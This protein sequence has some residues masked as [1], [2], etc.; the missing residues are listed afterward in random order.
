MAD[1]LFTP[2]NIDI[3]LPEQPTGG[4]GSLFGLA[5][6][7][8][9]DLEQAVERNQRN[10]ENALIRKVGLNPDSVLG[11]YGNLV[12]SAASGASRLAGNL[13]TLPLD[14]VAGMAQ[15]SVPE[16]RVQAYNRTLRGEATPEDAALLN[17]T[18][19]GDDGV[20]Q[21]YF[22]RLQ[23]TQGIQQASQK[24][25]DFFDIS[26][27]VDTTRRD[28]LS[29][30]IRESTASGVEQLRAAYDAYQN[31]DKYNA[32]V[33]GTQGAFRTIASALGT[34]VTDPGAVAEYV[35]EN[36][37][38]LALHAVAPAAGLATNLGYGADIQREGMTQ[39][40]A[41][42]EGQLPD[43]ED[44]RNMALW[45][46]AAA[47]A[48]QIGDVGLLK[49]IRAAGTGVGRAASGVATSTAREGVTEGFQT[50]AENEAQLKD[51][52]L[53]E[54]VEAA[55]IGALVGGTFQG[56]AE[57][58]NAV[59]QGQAPT[60]E[61][62]PTAEAVAELESSALDTGDV[63]A[64]AAVDPGRAISVLNDL[65]IDAAPEVVQAN[66]R[67]ADD[68]E[69]GLVTQIDDL[70]ANMENNSP[71]AVQEF[72]EILAE[73]PEDAPDAA[74]IRDAI[75]AS[76]SYT[77]A[78]RKQDEATVARLEKQLGEVRQVAERLRVDSTP[79]TDTVVAAAREGNADEALTLTMQNPDAIEPSVAAELSRN[80][81][82]PM[83]QR[84]A[85]STFAAAQEASNALKDRGAVN[86]DVFNGGPGFKGLNQ[87]R[88]A[89]R[90]A[91]NNGNTEKAQAEIQQLA[92]FA[93]T[94]ESKAA[95]ISAAYDSVKGSNKRVFIAPDSTGNWVQTP[96]KQDNG[97]VIN[98][99]SFRL[100]DDVAAEAKALRT[101]AS[102]FQAYAAAPRTTV[103]AEEVATA[104]VG[105]A[106]AAPETAPTQQVEAQEAN[107]AVAETGELTALRNRTGA[108]V[109]SD[110]Y[111]QVNLLGEMFSQETGRD[112][113]A[114]IRPLAAVQDFMSKVRSGEVN[115][116]DFLSQEAELSPNQRTAVNRFFGFQRMLDPFIKQGFTRRR[117]P[118]FRFQDYSQFLINDDGSVDENARTAIAMGSFTWIAENA[119]SIFNTDEGIN[120]ILNRDSEEEVS[121]EAYAVLGKVGTREDVV[122]NQL[123]GRIAQALG[124]RA[125]PEAAA[126]EQA[127]LESALGI[128]A[129]GAMVRAGLL[130]RTEISD[131]TIQRLR[132]TG[133]Q[134]SKAVHTFLNLTTK[135]VDGRV[136]ANDIAQQV[137]E[138]TTGSQSV[139]NKL[140][141][142][143][144]NGTEPSYTPVEF[145]QKFAKR[146]QQ[147]IPKVL[148]DT[149]NKEGAKAHRVRQDMFQ[150]WGNL[151]AQALYRIAGVVNDKPLHIENI[152]S[153]EAK[154]EG[155]MTQV[156]NFTA[157][158]DKMVADPTTDGLEQA[159]HFGRSVWK[160]QR[161]GL[162]TNVIN[163]QTS[164]VHRHMLAM[165]NWETEVDGNDP[166]QLN[167]FKLRVMEAFDKKTESKATALVLQDYDALVS[168]PEVKAAV[169]AIAAMLRGEQ[170][171]SVNYDDVITAAVDQAG[172]NFHSLDALVALA[173][174][175]NSTDGKFKTTFMG[176]VDG[177][178]NGP[179]LS[180]LMLGAKDYSVMNQG[181]FFSVA[182]QYT[183]FNDFKGAGNLDLY[184]STVK[185]ALARLRPEDSVGLAA[186]Q[187]ITG[188]LLTDEGNVT[189]KG[190]NVIKKPFTAMMFGSNT[191]TAVQ[192]MGQGFIDS[193]Y[194]QMERVAEKGDEAGMTQ[195]LEAV[196]TL[197]EKGPKL[198]AKMGIA[199][200]METKLTSAQ[201]NAIAS[202]FFGLLGQHVQSSLEDNYGVFLERRNT[203]NQSAQLAFRLYDAAFNAAVTQAE[204]T[205]PT[206]AR[207]KTRTGE[208]QVLRTLTST[209][210][211][212]IRKKLKPL[213]PILMTAMAKKSGNQ[214]DA[215]M[216][217][218]KSKRELDSSL[219]FSSEVYFG[220][221]VETFDENGKAMS[222]K[223]TSVNGMRTKAIDPGVAPFIT[224]I[225]ST[226]S[227]IASQ[228]Y[229]QMNALN[230]HDALG[231]GLHSVEEVGQKLN[232]ATF[233]NMRDYSAAS[234]MVNTLERTLT[235]LNQVMADP[236]M[237]AAIQ[238]ALKQISTELQRR[239]L[240]TIEDHLQRIRD[241]AVAADTQKLEMLASMKAV[242]QYATEGGSYMVTD[243]DR[244][245][246][247]KALDA[248]GTGFNDGA[249]A[250]A[251]NLDQLTQAQPLDL[252]AAAAKA[253]SN[254]SVQTL[255]PSTTLNVMEKIKTEEAARV[256]AVMESQN[257]PLASAK[258]VLEPH[259][260]AELVQQVAEN[261]K[262]KTSV[263]G[264]LGTPAIESNQILVDLL[265][266]TELNARQ[267]V[268]SLEALNTNG[269]T[270]R[271]LGMIKRTVPADMPI[272]YVTAET[273]PEGALGT[274]V[275][276][277]RGWFHQANDFK[278]IYIKSPD[279]VESGITPELLT[280]ELVHAALS[281]VVSQNL[282]GGSE[283]AVAVRDLM[284]LRDRASQFI[285]QNS[286]L[287][288]RYGNAVQ[289]VHELLAWG[290][291]NEG[292]Q[293]D[294]LAK[295]P[296]TQ[297]KSGFLNALGDFIDTMTRL[298]FRG[299]A[300]KA[301]RTGLGQL[302]AQSAGLFREASKLMAARNEQTM[303]YEDAVDHVNAMTAEEVLEALE[304]ASPRVSSSAHQG[305]MRDAIRDFVEPLYGP[306]GAFKEEASADR[307]MTPM[308]VYLKSLSTGQ[309]PFAS[310]A[311]TGPFQLNQQEGFVAESV[312]AVIEEAMRNP[313]TTF[314]RQAL[315]NL[316]NEAS[317]LPVAAFHRGDWATATSTEQALAQEKK[318]FLF[319]L[320]TGVTNKSAHLAQFAAMTIASE[321]VRAIMDFQ[322][323]G[324]PVAAKT[325]PIGT[326]LI[327][328]FQRAMAHLAS[329]YTKVKQG[330]KARDAAMTLV[331]QL[332]DIEAKHKQRM[333]DD[334]LSFLDQLETSVGDIG[335]KAR[336]RVNALASMP[337]FTQSSNG[338][339]RGA[340]AVLRTVSAQNTEE[341]L[342]HVTKL[343]DNVQRKQNGI[344]MGALEEMRGVYDGNKLAA[345]LF[346]GAKRIEKDR[347]DMIENTVAQVNA[348]FKD[349]GSYLTQED[350][351]AL[352]RGLLRTGAAVLHEAFGMQ[353]FQ[354]LIEQPNELKTERVKLEQQLKG[355]TQHWG[356]MQGAAKDL[357]YHKVV[358]GNVS[359]NLMLNTRNIARLLGTKVADT[360]STQDVNA[361]V[362]VL[363]QL[364]A[365]YALTYA[366]SADKTRITQV[367]RTEANRQDGNGVDFMMKLHTGLQ[368]QSAEQLFKGQEALQQFGYVP[369][370]HDNKIEVLLV[371]RRDLEKYE[372]AGYKVGTELQKD[373]TD[374][375]KDDRVLVTRRG[376]GQTALMTGSLSF[377][378]MHRK[379]SSPDRQTMN[380]MAG[381]NTTSVQHANQIKAAKADKIADLFSRGFSY[382]PTKVLAGVM[383]PVLHPDG[384]VVDFRYT[385]TEN[386]RDVLLDRDSSMDQVL[387][388][389]AGQIVDKVDTIQQ[390]AD[391]V[392]SLYDQYRA[393]YRDNPARF[394]KFGKSSTDPALAEMYRLL[395]ESTK[396]EI[397][398]VWRSDDMLIP[399]NQLNLIVGY[400]KY[401]L[402]EAFGKAERNLTKKHQLGDRNWAEQLFVM[403]TEAIF[404]EKAALRVG[405]AEDLMQELVKEAKD[406]L[407]VKNITTLVGNM[408]SNISLLAIE[409]VSVRNMIES[410]AV[411][412]KGAMDYRKDARR[413]MQLRQMLEV[414]YVPQGQQALEQ[415]LVQ[416]QDRM[417]RNPIKPLID[418]G[419][420]P[421]IV[422]DVE[423]DDSQYSYKSRLQKSVAK[424]TARV[425]ASLKELGKQVYMTHDTSVYKFLSQTTQLS[426]LVARY[427]LYQ[428]LTTRA[429]DPLSQ[430]DALAQAE[431]SFVN[432]DLPSHRSIQ[433]MNDMGLLMFT[434]YY[435]R[436]QKT[437]ARLVREKPARVIAGVALSHMIS[438]LQTVIDSTW[439]NR[440]GNNPFQ[441]GALNYPGTLD[442]LP[443]FKALN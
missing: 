53:E 239:E 353:R 221:E 24:V 359:H 191:A 389:M 209:E 277:A 243:A 159:L 324:I 137:R 402:T 241:V 189:S 430:A 440:I 413:V 363:D 400:R 28:R 304:G 373:S 340:G 407:V 10:V 405:Q 54:V 82:L 110:N 60:Q 310:K 36:A 346:K 328:L 217:M 116:N 443:V 3:Q 388:T 138:G 182:D 127:R 124:I 130:R 283:A 125:R 431:E 193:I 290:L 150:V 146:T 153:R 313:S 286:G 4:Q 427:A 157:F 109:T 113:D 338:Y 242:G 97:L 422:E 279:F 434:K 13:A 214:L 180:L 43:A 25:A 175:A 426:D 366:A 420:M 105:E 201:R 176:E 133:D 106:V 260:A 224:S 383:V 7:K 55:T 96:S 269:F 390:N 37:P 49:G 212:A 190:R 421:T 351:S 291:T 147:E 160:P 158:V 90:T 77:P 100:R 266:G 232:Q 155:L 134:P 244:A 247:Q 178:T 151:S 265:S 123:G 95:A 45:A 198:D 33:Q 61:N 332:V 48:E 298:L 282:K 226:D 46:A 94:R 18:A 172:A 199:V 111:Q 26:G 337:F 169:S 412:I 71:E 335:G 62:R 47:G 393:E 220:E 251:A 174:Q 399:A 330:D 173:H 23:G 203:I 293:Q 309:K 350:K 396:R 27:I 401:S 143:E 73:L 140:F 144:A 187:V 425:P 295:I 72:R 93:A 245:A 104:P 81:S 331:G 231:V 163:P 249:V 299:N 409:G 58:T 341:V 107:E 63:S 411:A 343:R 342:D 255:A 103:K 347:K 30:D 248:V 128:Q 219:P 42:N 258:T 333:I 398:R 186:L 288:S 132:A 415:E 35:A 92:S 99:A 381:T 12:A 66:L 185:G 149:L 273:G 225:H 297:T 348:N 287:N 267:L 433:F 387:G 139:L 418:A 154:N 11:Q 303:L 118:E 254:N 306:Y 152:A 86:S 321:E 252:Q 208:T 376:A 122:A 38:Q 204:Q 120:M 230:V 145:D 360:L 229:G 22:Q 31:G 322:V 317:K 305:R 234:E 6:Q 119:N 345:E 76:E 59:A 129:I 432:Y 424:Y 51:T 278:A 246:A 315:T 117:Q 408:I 394:L 165:D 403:L 184:E 88:S 205:S 271:L 89:I 367:L 272:K 161:V 171:V 202:S 5:A 275:S 391:V 370:I 222:R 192:D 307:A 263:W 34:G 142:V 364:T 262:P 98:A 235:G 115:I 112:T 83:E 126:N 334:R 211:D 162:N 439:L 216:H 91:L 257:I 84:E 312:Q 213:E 194:A 196:N 385:M 406:I 327:N 238:P 362:P 419:L 382:D 261:S 41:N 114:S 101:A 164:K 318:D 294:V 207:R 372:K 237:A 236:V 64:L 40:A 371:N 70:K 17:Q 377:T 369:E 210:L 285:S 167:N 274:G 74:A 179:M 32:I 325:A 188:Q 250:A 386:N 319:K 9:F 380:L 374:G 50:V 78:M 65:S 75:A 339:I 365:M 141:S 344:I 368:K 69:A 300:T 301:D 414:G 436:I 181:G 223:S 156:D 206:I 16:E 170:D 392:G 166:A 358:G 240:G 442:E 329:L 131:A 168:T 349:G 2:L 311:T 228:V 423:A 21:T 259:K 404:G 135:E 14:A 289:N 215:G 121:A 320:S 314:I 148:A 57:I 429:R 108:P 268:E 361:L 68:I 67:Q 1:S 270:A 410:H 316:F 177:L 218:S 302:V 276:K 323:Q 80:E 378:G 428:H 438:G 15:A 357:A 8:G 417:A 197:I 87:Y 280:H 29:D 195:I 227:A 355:M 20:P 56:G 395:P 437:I 264:E 253:L 379:G 183:Q 200:A 326:R 102:A 416:A 136:R 336:D 39:Y 308:D 352:T 435:M 85:L 296:S 284:A 79:D 19:L 233:E 397:R 44:R 441:W 356:Y 52:S 375:V 281:T 384:R 256:A 354:E 292:F